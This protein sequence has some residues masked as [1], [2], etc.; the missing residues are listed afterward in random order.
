MLSCVCPRSGVEQI[1]R[2]VAAVQ[3]DRAAKQAVG[4]WVSTSSGSVCRALVGVG[5]NAVRAQHRDAADAIRVRVGDDRE[6]DLAVQLRVRPVEQ[7]AGLCRAPCGV[8]QGNTAPGRDEQ[9]VRLRLLPLVAAVRVHQ[10]DPRLLRRERRHVDVVPLGRR[11][12][13][14]S[15]GERQRQPGEENGEGTKRARIALV[16]RGAEHASPPDAG[17][18]SRFVIAARR[19]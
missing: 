11:G 18:A 15:E 13:A 19:R 4:G 2:G 17:T 5:R 1:E 6:A 8:E 9:S 12:P 3:R 14:G 10:V 7:L 16:H